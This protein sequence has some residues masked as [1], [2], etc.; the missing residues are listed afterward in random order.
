MTATTVSG[1]DLRRP[2][3]IRPDLVL[4]GIV[5]ALSFLGLIM[6]YSTTAPRLEAV[7]ANPASEMVSQA[8]YVAMGIAV[9]IT[10][11]AFSD[12]TWQS[13]APVVYVIS[14]ILLLAVLSPVGAIRQGAQ[15]WISLGFMDLQP[16]EVAKPAVVMALAL[17]LAPAREGGVRWIRVAQAV[18]I[19]GVP[20]VLVFGQPDLGTALVFG[21]VTVVMLFVA[22]TSF[23]Q[24]AVLI[25]AAIIALVAALELGLLHD[26]Q[27]N[28]LVGFLNTDEHALSLNYN[29]NQSQIAIGAGGLFGQGLFQGTQTNLAFVP[30]QS[31]DFIFTAVGEQ[32]GF[33]GGALV[34]GLY[35][36]MIWR[37]LL[38]ANQARDRFAQLT[39]AGIAAMFAFHVFVNIGMTVGILPVT[40]IPLPFLSAGGS[41]YMSMMLAVGVVNSI[42]MRRIRPGQR[43]FTG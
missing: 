29:Q 41:F 10:A 35:G 34:L 2:T 21:F 14:A 23:R 19:A 38:V 3:Q 7:G 8:I 24:I 26:Y 22:G 9:L 30:E 32:L 6:I 39:A 4:I 31:T 20:A 36:L 15:R 33:A 25:V 43:P 18:A 13:L 17:L 16:S 37:M 12:R 27:I 5:A 28:R 11:S 42:W 1:V 40:G